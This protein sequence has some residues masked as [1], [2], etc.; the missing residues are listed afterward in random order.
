M[1]NDVFDLLTYN[2]PEVESTLNDEVLL[3]AKVKF[4]EAIDTL[5][6]DKVY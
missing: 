1:L 5:K 6:K 2:L 3:N 4:S